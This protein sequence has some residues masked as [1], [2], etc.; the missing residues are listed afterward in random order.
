MIRGESMKRTGN[1][2]S[3]QREKENCN[4]K[5]KRVEEQTGKVIHLEYCPGDAKKE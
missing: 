3:L 1:E 5:R 2:D 4:L